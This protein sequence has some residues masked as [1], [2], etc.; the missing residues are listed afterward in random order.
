MGI[1]LALLVLAVLLVPFGMFSLDPPTP[2]SRPAE[3]DD[4]APT[5]FSEDM[6][7]RRLDALADELD[8]LERD[9]DVFARAFHTNVARTAYET[10]VADAAQLAEETRRVV[11]G[12]VEFELLESSGGGACAELEL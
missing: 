7:R 5:L 8:R 2:G 11:A 12:T 3:R 9:P 1:L 4:E 6:I 10:L